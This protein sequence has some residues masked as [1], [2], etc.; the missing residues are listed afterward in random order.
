[1]D[2]DLIWA[3]GLGMVYF[4]VWRRTRDFYV[5][6]REFRI[7]TP[8]EFGI[9]EKLESTHYHHFD[10]YLAARAFFDLNESYRASPLYENQQNINYIYAV[11]ASTA[12]QAGTKMTKRPYPESNILITTPHSALRE[13][14]NIGMRSVKVEL[15]TMPEPVDLPRATA[16]GGGPLLPNSQASIDWP[17]AG[18]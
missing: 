10:D 1:M 8:M 15:G 14:K 12:R 18:C 9:G 11:L 17:S 7:V 5:A 2:R 16:D 4:L 3:I 6:I 13:L